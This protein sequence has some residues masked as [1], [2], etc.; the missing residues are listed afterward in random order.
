MESAVI[1]QDELIGTGAGRKEVEIELVATSKDGDIARSGTD[2]L[3]TESL[4][5]CGVECRWDRSDLLPWDHLGVLVDL[6]TEVVAFGRIRE[7]I[8]WNGNGVTELGHDH[9]SSDIYL[10]GFF[11]YFSS[12]FGGRG[13]RPVSRI[14]SEAD[15]E[16]TI[17]RLVLGIVEG[18]GEGYLIEGLRIREKRSQGTL[19]PY[20]HPRA[21]DRDEEEYADVPGFLC[22]I[23][24]HGNASSPPKARLFSL[25]EYSIKNGF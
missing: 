7:E 5:V 9:A 15:I 6:D 12:R 14:D 21:Y 10:F 3:A 23:L 20:G 17:H 13:I 25:L 16:G 8:L 4:C 2:H 11:P 24:R 18:E 1:A 19:P 22:Y